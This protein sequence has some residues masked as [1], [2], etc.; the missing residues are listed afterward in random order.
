MNDNTLYAILIVVIG[1]VVCF[2]RWSS[3]RKHDDFWNGDRRDNR[4]N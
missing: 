3:V 1:A 4:D 2:G